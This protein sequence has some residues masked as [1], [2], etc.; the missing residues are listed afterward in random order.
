MNR[1]RILMMADDE[2]VNS[3]ITKPSG[4]DELVGMAAR[5]NKNWLEFVKL[6]GAPAT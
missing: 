3:F 5:L 4:F 2:G 1:D 6:P